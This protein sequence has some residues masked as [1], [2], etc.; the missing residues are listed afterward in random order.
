MEEY[1]VDLMK[2]EY[3]TEE[4]YQKAIT[5]K[6][7][8]APAQGECVIGGEPIEIIKVQTIGYR[9]TIEKKG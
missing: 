7:K 1:Q 8:A 2:K 5:E 9:L 3:P 4:A 6:W